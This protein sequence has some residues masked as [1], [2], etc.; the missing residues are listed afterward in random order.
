MDPALT[1][2]PEPPRPARAFPG[3]G[4]SPG[5]LVPIALVVAWLVTLVML[6][7]Y[8]WR[9]SLYVCAYCA[10]V[11][12]FFQL[13]RERGT[14]DILHPAPG[15]M[16]L[17]LLYS[18]ASGLFG[19]S[20]GSTYFGEPLLE[21]VYWRY[22]LACVLGLLGLVAG[23]SAGIARGKW[24]LAP[25][26]PVADVGSELNRIML[27]TALVLCA[28]TF[29]WIW[30][31]LDFLTVRAYREVAL[32]LRV[33]RL[34][35]ELSGVIDVLTLYLPLTLMLAVCVRCIQSSATPV[36]GRLM[37]VAV[38]AAYFAT[39]FLGGERYTILFCAI[40]LLAYR[41]YHVQPLPVTWV[42]AWAITAYLLM[43]LIPILRYTSDPALMTRIF[44]EVVERDGLAEFSLGNSNELLTATNL[45]RQIQGQLLGETSFNYG[46]SIINDLLVWI[47]RPLFLGERP[48]P[49]S[50]QFVDVFYPGIREIGGGYGFFII[51]E[52]Y[53]AL[54][55]AGCFIFMAFFGFIVER[56][57]A[58]AMQFRE[59]EFA[60]L[61]YA[62]VYADLVMAS[63]RSG[64]VGSF[65]S[66]LLHSAP[67]MLVLGIHQIVRW[68][69][70]G[71]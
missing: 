59:L 57:H 69:R 34:A 71:G 40:L 39:G 55:L 28:L 27:V 16:L 31:K 63:V 37:A 7:E 33:E 46:A 3:E 61:W 50:E 25:A 67:F 12:L 68:W 43:N 64:V 36:L 58:L 6:R 48:L 44:L 51:Q 56:V 1:S 30:D 60:T 8:H 45:F 14:W 19:E 49:T 17:L 11:A 2:P 18:L 21:E 52:G 70:R 42:L 29:P 9:L 65:K 35:N 53:W 41:H 10:I 47:P 13:T 24:A 26:A 15:L 4:A 22:Y 62:A 54:G 66:A 5:L 20:R 38:F 23:I 32:T